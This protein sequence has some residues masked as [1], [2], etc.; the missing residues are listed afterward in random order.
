MKKTKYKVE[1]EYSTNSDIEIYAD[2]DTDAEDVAF[3]F[4]EKEGYIAPMITKV[5]EVE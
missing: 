2:S 5:T 4:F 3:D 1:F